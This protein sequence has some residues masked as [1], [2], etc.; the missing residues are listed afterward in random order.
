MLKRLLKQLNIQRWTIGLIAL[1][2]SS[3][4]SASI[5]YDTWDTNEA[6]SGNYIL[7]IDQ[8]GG[9]F[10]YNLTVDPWNAEALGIFFDLGNV[11]VANVGLT[12]IAPAGEVELFSTDTSSDSCGP[13]CNL[14]GLSP[15]LSPGEDWEL[16]FRLGAQGFDSI[17]T[18]SWSTSDFG[19]TLDDF[20]L[21]GIR[22]QQ[23]CDAGSTLDNGT[24]N[25]EGSDKSS[26]SGRTVV[27]V[28]EPATL[29]LLGLGLFGVGF[30]RRFIK[31]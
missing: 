17:Q 10:N 22:A 12:N 21:V 15:L 26:G 18:F 8:S 16:V 7:S 4:S 23:L 31:S 1:G 9:L 14:S 29:A 28:P 24:N 3:A 27:T 2:L 19:L 20:G 25:C 13:S 6:I 30:R 11:A 5:I